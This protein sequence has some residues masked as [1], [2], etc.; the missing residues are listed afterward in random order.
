[1]VL[2]GLTTK[3]KFFWKLVFWTKS[4]PYVNS[5]R[6]MA[7]LEKKNFYQSLFNP[8]NTRDFSKMTFFSKKK[9]RISELLGG[10]STESKCRLRRPNNFILCKI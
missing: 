10:V 7:F 4:P 6:F 1:M 8:L 9:T 5:D 2:K 3:K